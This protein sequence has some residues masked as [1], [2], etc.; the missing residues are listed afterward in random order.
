M[1]WFT[2]ERSNGGFRRALGLFSAFCLGLGS[3]IGSGIYISPGEAAVAG[4]F[5]LLSWIVVGLLMMPIALSFARFGMLFTRAGGAYEYVKSAMGSAW[6]VITGVGFWAAY[7]AVIA[8]LGRALSRYAS[9]VFPQAGGA[10]GSAAMAIAAIWAVTAA[11]LVGVRTGGLLNDALTAIK[12]LPL[13]AFVALLAPH[14]ALENFA[15]EGGVSS[16]AIAVA[17]S[18]A[19]WAYL[20]FEAVN[21]PSEEIVRPERNIPRGV[22][23]SVL[24]VMALYV[25]VTAVAVGSASAGALSSSPAPL[26]YAMYRFYGGLAGRAMF[27]AASVSILGCLAATILPNARVAYALARD[28][29]F[30]RALARLNRFGVP[31]AALLI[32]AA[33]ASALAAA[34]GFVKLYL[35]SDL[36]SLIPYLAVS[37]SLA[38]WDGEG[39]WRAVGVMGALAS[40]YLMYSV[41]VAEPETLLGLGVVIAASLTAYALAGRGRVRRRPWPQR[42][43]GPGAEV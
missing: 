10:T 5:S 6:G 40:A 9:F 30:P 36:T 8:T 29:Y 35:I 42:R 18:A 31:S 43:R 1:V 22:V 12:L 38:L 34:Y 16:E 7:V 14:V 23:Y 20:G 24:A 21:P 4:P 41:L 13:L 39:R 17:V 25:A 2:L 15:P 26:A 33:L 3:M 37:L 32:Q 11:N 28:S 27:V 19:L